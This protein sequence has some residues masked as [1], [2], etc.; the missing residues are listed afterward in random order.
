MCKNLGRRPK[1]LN[2]VIFDQSIRRIQNTR[3]SFDGMYCMLNV[4][5]IKKGVVQ[6]LINFKNVNSISPGLS[7]IDHS[8]NEHSQ[9]HCYHYQYGGGGIL[10]CMFSTRKKIQ[11]KIIHGADL[12]PARQRLSVML[13]PSISQGFSAMQVTPSRADGCLRHQGCHSRMHQGCK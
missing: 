8:V 7:C 4:T 11:S 9:V 13:S 6:F 10:F 12:V 5:V 1:C 2:Y 3:Y